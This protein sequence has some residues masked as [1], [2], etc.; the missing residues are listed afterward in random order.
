MFTLSQSCNLE[1]PKGEI[2]FKETELGSLISRLSDLYI[3]FQSME[4]LNFSV[5]G[6]LVVIYYTL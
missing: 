4:S 1:S 3:L 5:L 6:D 2:K